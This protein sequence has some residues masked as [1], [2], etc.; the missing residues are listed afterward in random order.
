MFDIITMLICNIL[1]AH[2][3]WQQAYVVAESMI[4]RESRVEMETKSS[5]ASQIWRK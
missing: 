3:Q 5:Y 2:C 4:S 1:Y